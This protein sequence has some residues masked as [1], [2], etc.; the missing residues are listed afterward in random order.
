METCKTHQYDAWINIFLTE[1]CRQLIEHNILNRIP[2]QKCTKILKWALRFEACLR[3]AIFQRSPLPCSSFNAFF[4][5]SLLFFT[6]LFYG[7]AMN[8][9]KASSVYS[10]SRKISWMLTWLPESWYQRGCIRTPPDVDPCSICLHTERKTQQQKTLKLS[11]FQVFSWSSVFCS[12]YPSFSTLA[13]S[14][15]TF[16]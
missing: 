5:G 12:P 15:F 6:S 9:H 13:P 8:N 16:T 14:N 3:H 7:T 1:I 11:H 4:L 2:R 10:N